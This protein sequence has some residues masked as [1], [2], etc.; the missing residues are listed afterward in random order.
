[1]IKLTDNASTLNKSDLLKSI[2]E[3]I[4]GL[5]V[6]MDGEVNPA[7]KSRYEGLI[8]ELRKIRDSL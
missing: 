7:S 8:N 2:H 4:K 1:M 6:L 3:V 5:K